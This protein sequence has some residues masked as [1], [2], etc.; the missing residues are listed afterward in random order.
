MYGFHAT[1]RIRIVTILQIGLYWIFCKSVDYMSLTEFINNH[2]IRDEMRKILQFKPFKIKDEIKAANQ[3]RQYRSFQ[4]A[5]KFVHILKLSGRNEWVR[6][7]KT[8]KKPKDIPA[9]PSQSY[10]KEWKGSPVGVLDSEIGILDKIQ[11]H[12]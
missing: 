3:N 2:E 8:S 7:A 9:N 6:Y 5:R 11:D 4:E 10:K 1:T 12:F